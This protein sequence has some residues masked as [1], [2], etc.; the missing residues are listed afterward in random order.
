MI[1]GRLGGA[2]AFRNTETSTISIAALPDDQHARS[3]SLLVL[4]IYVLSDT[5]YLTNQLIS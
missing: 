1:E 3:S 2:A 4:A 5:L